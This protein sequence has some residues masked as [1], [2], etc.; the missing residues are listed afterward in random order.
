MELNPC[1]HC[2]GKEFQTLPDNHGLVSSKDALDEAGYFGKHTTIL[3][4]TVSI[5]TNC[6][7]LALSYS[8]NY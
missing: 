7:H 1:P 5:C 3:P 2:G 6:E 8:R 4:V